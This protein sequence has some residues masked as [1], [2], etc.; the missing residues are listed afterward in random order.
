MILY[1]LE[2]LETCIKKLKKYFGTELDMNVISVDVKFDS[3]Y[4]FVK[5]ISDEVDVEEC[6][7][8][9]ESIIKYY[10]NANVFGTESKLDTVAIEF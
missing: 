9:Y 3:N 2:T 6:V 8:K 7:S 5:F 10:Y 1:E 4:L